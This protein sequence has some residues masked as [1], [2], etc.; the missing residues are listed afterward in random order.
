MTTP[1]TVCFC[2]TGCSRDEGEETR[3]WARRDWQIWMNETRLKSDKRIYCKTT[4]YI[5]VQIH[6]EI[7]NNNLKA[8]SNS[9]TIR[10]VGEN[11][12]ADQMDS[13]DQLHFD[14]LQIPK[15]LQQYVHSYSKD[16][17]RSVPSQTTGWA[18][19]ALALHGAN[20]AARSRAK[21]YNF[22]GHS[23]GA[24]ECIMAAWFI[25]TYFDKTIPI[26][27]FAIDPVP[28]S[29]EWY[30]ILTQ[31]PPNVVNYVG[32]YAWDH[33]DIGF[34]ALV[35][36]PNERMLRLQ[37]NNT[38]NTINPD[39]SKMADNCQLSDPLSPKA[40]PQPQPVGYDLFACRGR[41][42]TVAGNTTRDGLYDPNKVSSAVA[43]VPELVYKMAR[44]YLTLWGTVFPN[45]SQVTRSVIEL[46]QAIHSNHAYFDAMGKGATRT[47]VFPGRPYVRQVSSIRGRNSWDTYYL[48][49]VVGDPPYKL[50]YPVTYNRRD[51]GWVNWNFL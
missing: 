1:Y 45:P 48:D 25:Y 42:S 2:G 35:P 26:N 43:P 37:T 19:T 33:L 50:S 14:K 12:W 46:R 28:G 15:A 17:Q 9:I 16:N 24:V 41:Y 30:G 6:K 18:A 13:S 40:G 21:Q 32:I 27:I 38:P 11:D 51:G 7:S 44:G 49:N 20:A 5:P 39:W 36:R 10:G 4:G 22:L 29:G 3:Q 23:R 47:S 31:L 8:T 34:S